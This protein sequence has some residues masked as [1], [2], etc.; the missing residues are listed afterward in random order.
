GSA[1]AV[2]SPRRPSRAELIPRSTAPSP[3]PTRAGSSTGASAMKA[4][5]RPLPGKGSG[6]ARSSFGEAESGMSSV[7]APTARTS[8]RTVSPGALRL[9]A[10]RSPKWSRSPTGTAPFDEAFGVM[11]PLVERCPELRHLIHA[12]LLNFNVLVEDDRIGALLD[13]GSAMFGD[14]LYDLAWLS[15]WWPFFPKWSQVD[16]IA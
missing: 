10:Y 5:W 9:L 13:W 11:A 7:S 2:A 8:T 4:M 14:F 15:F 6:R 1:R 12:D 16:V 3:R